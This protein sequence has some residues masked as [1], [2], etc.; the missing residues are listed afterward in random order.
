M[1]L[2]AKWVAVAVVFGSILAALSAD[3]SVD[4]DSTTTRLVSVNYKF[5]VDYTHIKIMALSCRAEP[6]A[7]RLRGNLGLYM[8]K[9]LTQL[10]HTASI[11]EL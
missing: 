5:C 4:I 8:T 7:D 3:I 2:S 6:A 1:R 10:C 9:S 11:A